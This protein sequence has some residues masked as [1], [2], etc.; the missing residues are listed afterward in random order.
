M[1]RVYRLKGCSR[2]DR[3]LPVEM[4]RGLYTGT[5]VARHA[6]H[7]HTPERRWQWVGLLDAVRPVKLGAGA[8]RR[9]RRQRYI[10]VKGAVIGEPVVNIWECRP[11]R[12]WQSEPFLAEEPTCTSAADRHALLSIATSLVR[13]G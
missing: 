2:R 11:W 1:Q 13:R 8:A 5:D 12:Q 10:V 3:V 6:R 7:R 9:R 4:P